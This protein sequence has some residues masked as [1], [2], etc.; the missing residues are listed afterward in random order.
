MKTE[1]PYDDLVRIILIGDSGVGKTSFLNR[2]C[3]GTFKHNIQC[4][5]GLEYGQKVIK[6]NQRKI[7][8]QLWDT[9]G[10]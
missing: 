10:Q 5:V 9:A 7:M 8:I 4:T 6:Q 1:E 3:Y 2:F